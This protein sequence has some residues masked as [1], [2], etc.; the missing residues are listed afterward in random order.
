VPIHWRGYVEPFKQGWSFTP[1][2]SPLFDDVLA[3][4]DYD[5]TASQ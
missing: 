4:Q 3:N 2:Q 5:F 1:A